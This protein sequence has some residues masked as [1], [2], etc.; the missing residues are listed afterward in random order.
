MSAN[1]MELKLIFSVV[2]LLLFSLSLVQTEET[3]EEG[4]AKESNKELKA[5][6]QKVFSLFSIVSFK[7]QGCQSQSG[8]T[9]TSA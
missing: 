7:N 6:D 9:G 3:Y 2:A 5:R 8:T 4:I 1:K